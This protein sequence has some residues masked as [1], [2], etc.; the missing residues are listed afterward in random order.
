M[1]KKSWHEIAQKAGNMAVVIKSLL[2]DARPLSVDHDKVVIGIDPEF[3]DEQERLK[4]SR[5]KGAVEH[6]V[7]SFLG[8]SVKVTFKVADLEAAAAAGP[9]AVREAPKP[10]AE[11]PHKE[12]QSKGQAKTR[13]DLM[14]DPA[15][16]KALDMFE[17]SVV[18]VRE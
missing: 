18:D 2:V 1:T 15:V 8:R 12:K 16:Q 4:D 13:G 6:A 14:K 9:K 5:S 11:A 10:Q 7:S 17:G 3:A